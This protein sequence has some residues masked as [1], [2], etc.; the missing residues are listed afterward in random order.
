M[1]LIKSDQGMPLSRGEEP[2]YS[3][4]SPYPSGPDLQDGFMDY[5]RIIWRR[6]W[7]IGSVA[8]VC[9]LLGL[10]FAQFSQPIYTARTTLEVQDVIPSANSVSATPTDNQVYSALS[11]IQTQVH[12]LQSEA[13]QTRTLEKLEKSGWKGVPGRAIVSI[14]TDHKHED[15]EKSLLLTTADSMKVREAGPTRIIEIVV[16]S[17]DKYLAADYANTAANEFIDQNMEARWKMGQRTGEWLGRELSDMRAKLESSE[18]SLEAYAQKV[19]LLFA[20]TGIGA[21]TDARANVSGQKLFELQTALST[22]STE[23]VSKQSKYSVANSGKTEGIPELLNDPTL[24]EYQT[25]LT[26]LKRQIAELSAVYTPDFAKLKRLQGQL[27]SVQSEFDRQKAAVVSKIKNE[28]DEAILREKLL[29]SVFEN[30]ERTVTSD[31]KKAIAYNLLKR[32]VDTNRQLYDSMLQRVKESAVNAA[33]KASNIRVVDS[34]QVPRFRSKP[35]KKLDV[36][37]GF[38]LGSLI[39]IA[40]VVVRDKSDGTFRTPGD[41]PLWLNVPE[42]GVVP[43]G[44]VR[45][46]MRNA[47]IPLSLEAGSSVTAVLTSLLFANETGVSPRM[48]V[49]TSANPGEGKTTIAANIALRCSEVGKKVLLID[50]DFAQPRLHELFGLPNAH[51]FST[52]V[53]TP[54]LSE[55]EIKFCVHQ[56]SPG[57]S[58]L[59][60]GPGVLDASNLLFAGHVSE[61][62]ARLK[63][64]YQMVIIDTPPTPQFAHARVLG[65]MADG[66][67]V[68]MRSGKTSREA[69]SATIQ[70][71]I[72]D[73]SYVLGT[74]L[75]DWDTR[76]QSAYQWQ[77][78]NHSY[79]RYQPAVG[80]DTFEVNNEA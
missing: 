68:V 54:G 10:A 47:A 36:A 49:F 65:R 27:D 9:A 78:G 46:E 58:I 7:T 48:I 44:G 72:A 24:R 45:V 52:V 75:N 29:T 63:T 64:M 40:F 39:G 18:Y 67:V 66:I 20:N 60:S 55:Q 12:I 51:G 43:R 34:A 6:K 41:S 32:E 80:P 31:A 62:L 19:G 1:S 15:P 5:W 11:D 50:A 35:S 33:L 17:A 76:N 16:D 79:A 26:D 37:M 8:F 57:L 3:A 13:I 21:N 71:L 38:F 69:A 56:V 14:A 61:V 42:L 28:Y 30:Q 22:A 23:R 4:S 2:Q 77:R 70:R 59:P 53:Q 25:K 74:I 73:G